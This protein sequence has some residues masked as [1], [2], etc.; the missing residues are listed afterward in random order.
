MLIIHE[1]ESKNTAYKCNL[2]CPVQIVAE[3]DTTA[4][5]GIQ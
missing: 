1:V 4:V 5:F 2:V 3:N